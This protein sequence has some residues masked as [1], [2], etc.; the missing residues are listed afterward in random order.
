M[1]K[2]LDWLLRGLTA[3]ALVVSGVIH[4]QLAPNYPAGLWFHQETAFRVQ[5]VV[6]F[7]LAAAVL[8]VPRA[9]RLIW[10]AC[11]AV[12]LGSLS[13]LLLSRYFNVMGY[14]PGLINEHLWFFKKDV[15]ALVEGIAIVTSL[16]GVALAG[17][18]AKRHGPRHA[19][20]TAH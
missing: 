20:A 6:V 3:F 13:A 14:L 2:T 11:A 18:S 9:R 5:A 15:V 8:L 19:R 7:V 4:L 1:T 16:A 10:L 12:A 17:T